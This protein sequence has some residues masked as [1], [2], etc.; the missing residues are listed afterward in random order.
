MRAILLYATLITK[1]EIK[2]NG[3]RIRTRIRNGTKKM[4]NKVVV[5]V[6]IWIRTL[7]KIQKI[8]KVKRVDKI[9]K[10]KRN[11]ARTIIRKVHS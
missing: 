2:K 8:N 3:R 11:R 9:G 5:A 1:K 10:T 7:L 4:V 6:R